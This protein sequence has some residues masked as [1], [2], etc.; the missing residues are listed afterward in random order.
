MVTQMSIKN[1]AFCL[2]AYFAL[3]L[4][5]NLFPAYGPPNF[6]YTG[7]DPSVHVWNLGWPLATAIYD[8]RSGFHYAPEAFFLVAYEIMVLFVGV[9]FAVL[10]VLQRS[11][12]QSAK[13][14]TEVAPLQVKL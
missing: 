1:A 7:S 2:A 10:R 3:C 5:V 14:A 6:R 11:R 9:F 12:T 4:F 8:P 13:G